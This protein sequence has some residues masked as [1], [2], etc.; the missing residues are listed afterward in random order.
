MTRRKR[1]K[2]GRKANRMGRQVLEEIPWGDIE[3]VTGKYP[4]VSM[5]IQRRNAKGQLQTL[6]SSAIL[7]AGELVNLE[8]WLLD[9][10]GGGQYEIEIKDPNGGIQ[11]IIPR[12]KVPIEA[13][14]RPPKF[15]GAAAETAEYAA[16]PYGP[17]PQQAPMR[18]QH[19][20]PPWA[21]GL[22][23][24][25]QTFYNGRASA[26][27]PAPG[28]TVASDQ[29]AMRA[30]ADHK[31][32]TAKTIS[33]LEAMVE[34]LADENK[35]KDEA[36][37]AER[38][39]AR[40]ERHK[41]ELQRI[42]QMLK[43]QMEAGNKQQ[44]ADSGMGKWIEALPALAPV[45]AAM[46]TARESST[47][48]SLEVQQQ[49]LTTLMNATLSQANKPDSTSEMLKTFAPLLLPF[50]KDIMEQKSPAAQAQLFNSMVENN[51]SQVAM[52]AQ[53]IEAFASQGDEDPWWLPVI[54]ETL[55]GVVGMTEAYMQS[56][57]GLPGQRP[58][59]QQLGS[60]Q[61]RVEMPP[62]VIDDA[63]VG[64]T[65]QTVK[66]NVIEAPMELSNPDKAK[67]KAKRATEQ[68]MTGIK[69]GNGIEDTLS[70]KERAMLSMLPAEFQSVEWRAIV[71]TVEREHDVEE[72]ADLCASHII[73][74]INFNMLP[75]SLQDV[76]EDPA[77]ALDRV[78][79]PLPVMSRNRDYGV[80]LMNKVIDILIE[81]E[82]VV[83]PPTIVEE[84]AEVVEAPATPA[85]QA[86]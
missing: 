58:A 19:P 16:N 83:E 85:A 21:A 6:T 51:L 17:S 56:R 53:L 60:G 15:L 1:S 34:K 10:A 37:A 81:E 66:S 32:E 12:F 78:L 26:A 84:E 28:A 64:A 40:E 46:V 72:V 71:V 24:Q 55:G 23:P 63:P 13:P 4:K 9:F 39:R 35:R 52:M 49:G 74:L 27:R 43:M 70:V 5:R 7:E 31:A 79:S 33:K 82:A 48:K 2:R 20:S 76:V 67:S 68:A 45:L 42:E 69:P 77:R 80:D 22:H 86:S 8:D 47:S 75:E 41:S 44:P 29:L 62:E 65:Y 73:H 30:L 25:Q 57:G 50:I 59:I 61:Q 14:I 18:H 3:D 11:P 54:K 38:E 36:L